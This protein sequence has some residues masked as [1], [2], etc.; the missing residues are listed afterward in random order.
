MTLLSTIRK[1]FD[2]TLLALRL[3]LVVVMFS[4]GAQQYSR[5]SPSSLDRSC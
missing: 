2:A 5:F 1:L 4:Q 3:A